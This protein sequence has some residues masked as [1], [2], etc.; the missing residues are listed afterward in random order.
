MCECVDEHKNGM[1][2]RFAR[3]S[4]PALDGHTQDSDIFLSELCTRRRH[5]LIGPVDADRLDAAWLL[6]CRHGCRFWV[7]WTSV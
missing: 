7:S 5:Q 6:S 4:S 3:S 1:T 2:G